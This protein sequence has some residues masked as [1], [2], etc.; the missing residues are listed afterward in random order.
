MA[1]S[2]IAI[3]L[4]AGI[5]ILQLGVLSTRLFRAETPQRAPTRAL[6]AGDSLGRLRTI[7]AAGQSTLTD[8]TAGRPTVLLA[9]DTSCV[10]CDSIA[11]SWSTWTKSANRP[12]L[13]GITR[14]PLA[15]GQRYAAAHDW[16]LDAIVQ[17]DRTDVGGAERTLTSKTPWLFALDANGSLLFED[18]GA[19]F[20][21]VASIPAPTVSTP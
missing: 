9:F 17:L 13:V 7:D 10:W 16:V 3:G 2:R 19:N 5:A 6:V 12:R 21:R 4:L 11:P 18:H 14:A 8:V 15:A 20:G 1:S